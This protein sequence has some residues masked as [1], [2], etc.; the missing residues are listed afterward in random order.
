MQAQARGERCNTQ[1]GGDAGHLLASCG[2][3]PVD[4][5]EV[6]AQLDDG[7]QRSKSETKGEVIGD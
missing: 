1:S 7:G 4:E 2:V 3:L 6:W 5:E